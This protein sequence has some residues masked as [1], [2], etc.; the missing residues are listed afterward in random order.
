MLSKDNRVLNF[1]KLRIAERQGFSKNDSMERPISRFKYLPC[2]CPIT[3][4]ECVEWNIEE[5]QKTFVIS[6]R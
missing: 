6:I 1:E 3:A 5:V 2:H 4:N